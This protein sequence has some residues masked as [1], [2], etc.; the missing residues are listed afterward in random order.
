MSS[1]LQF[2]GLYSPWNSLGQNTRVGSHS[3]FQGIFPTQGSSGGLLRCRW[4]LYQLSHQE[5]LHTE[6]CHKIYKLHLYKVIEYLMYQWKYMLKIL[7]RKC[8]MTAH[9]LSKYTWFLK[10]LENSLQLSF[11]LLTRFAPR[12]CLCGSQSGCLSVKSDHVFW[13]CPTKQK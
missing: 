11:Y 8:F 9:L 13:S 6:R 7:S 3:P 2:L 4:L 12:A 10:P 5:G 1:S